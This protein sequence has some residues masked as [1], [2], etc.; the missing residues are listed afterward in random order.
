MGL[1]SRFVCATALLLW[2]VS[3]A[4]A[5]EVSGPARVIDGDTLEV[6]GVTVRLFGIDAPE[7]DQPCARS[8]GGLWACGDWVAARLDAQIAGARIT[9]TGART[10]RY[11][12]LIA[13]CAAP[14]SGDL[15]AWL[16]GTGMARAYRRYS[17]DYVPQEQRAQRAQRGLWAG[18]WADPAAHRAAQQAQDPPPAGTGGCLIKGNISDSGRIYHLP[19]SRSYAATRIDAA[20]GERWFCSVAEAEAA[21]WRAPHG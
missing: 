6:A 21:G 3:G 1:R 19:G 4:A 2:A 5:R 14:A 15:G 8:D 16:V 20:A 17:V 13:R 10:D 7:R 11:D 9:C 12:R 18:L